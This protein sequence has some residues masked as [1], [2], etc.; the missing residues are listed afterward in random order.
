LGNVE[1]KKG[2]VLL[3]PDERLITNEKTASFQRIISECPCG[4]LIT[5]FH[6]VG[7]HGPEMTFT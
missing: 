7:L 4:R 1:L 2:L 6:E 3:C 5:A